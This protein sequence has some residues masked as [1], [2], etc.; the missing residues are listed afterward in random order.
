MG[1]TGEVSGSCW[2]G[3]R[4]SAMP[5]VAFTHRDGD[6]LGAEQLSRRDRWGIWACT[7][8]SPSPPP[9]RHTPSGWFGGFIWQLHVAG[10]GAAPQEHSGAAGQPHHAGGTAGLPGSP[11]GCG[12]VRG[13]WDPQLHHGAGLCL[14]I[15]APPFLSCKTQHGHLQ[16]QW[17]RVPVGVPIQGLGVTKGCQ[18]PAALSP[19]WA[20]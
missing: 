13:W 15:A 19:A 4:G 10:G 6:K 20:L 11:Q 5:S 16:G 1:G 9:H 12:A 14:A 17:H 2:H 8:L 7:G 18:A 3:W